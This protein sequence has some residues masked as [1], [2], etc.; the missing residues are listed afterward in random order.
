MSDNNVTSNQASPDTSTQTPTKTKNRLGWLLSIFGIIVVSF[1][2]LV[3][4]VNTIK[5]FHDLVFGSPQ[6]PKQDIETIFV[7][8]YSNGTDA[9]VEREWRLARGD[10]AMIANQ[11]AACNNLTS[12]PISYAVFNQ[13]FLNLTPNGDHRFEVPK[14][15]T[16]KPINIIND[17][18]LPP[19]TLSQYQRE[20]IYLSDAVARARIDSAAATSKISPTL[21]WFQLLGL[22][23][24]L[25]GT[26][27]ITVR[28]SLDKLM[29]KVF[30]GATVGAYIGFLAMITSAFGNAF[31]TYKEQ[32][33]ASE[34]YL[35]NARALTDLRGL[36]LKLIMA[37]LEY[38]DPC[39]PWIASPGSSGPQ[40]TPTQPQGPPQGP[41]QKVNFTPISKEQS[42]TIQQSMTRFAEIVVDTSPYVVK[43]P[44]IAPPAPPPPPG[45]VK[46][47]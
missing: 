38:S 36:H 35:R 7:A 15:A 31:N 37:V 34:I 46:K 20:M 44:N 32:N 43:S 5:P 27:L 40:N 24:G 28:S 25:A 16:G 30:L 19:L 47:K 8:K 12:K 2:F 4:A 10:H 39:P 6:T 42:E 9:D 22:G 17:D 45:D 26:F 18:D 14:D 21:Q 13:L 3:V 11:I 41:Q 29:E 33:N 1:V 23:F